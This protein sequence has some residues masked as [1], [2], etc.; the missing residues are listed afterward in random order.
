MPLRGFFHGTRDALY[1]S[2]DRNQVRLPYY[3]R[4][5][6]RANKA[7]IRDRY[8]LTLF[9][10]VINITNRENIRLEDFFQHMKH[11]ALIFERFPRASESRS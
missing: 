2:T 9:A 5:D 1:L 10:E 7:F 11:V 6:L 3:G 4:L 8:R